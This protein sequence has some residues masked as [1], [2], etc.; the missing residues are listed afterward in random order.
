MP[1]DNA[2]SKISPVSLKSSDQQRK[3]V[4]DAWTRERKISKGNAEKA[5]EKYGQLI[6]K[7][8]DYNS[9][10][11]P[12]S[13]T[14]CENLAEVHKVLDLEGDIWVLNAVQ[15]RYARQQGII[16]RL[17]H[18]TQDELTDKGKGDPVT[19]GLAIIQVIWMIVQLIVR[20]ATNKPSSP[21]ELATL[22]FATLAFV[23]YVLLF[24]HPKDVNTPF[25]IL[26]CRLPVLSEVVQIA[27]LSSDSSAAYLDESTL[28]GSI[29]NLTDHSLGTNDRWAAA[30]YWFIGSAVGGLV[31]GG[32]HLLAWN[33][34]F[35][36]EAERVLWIISC[37]ITALGPLLYITEDIVYHALSHPKRGIWGIGHIETSWGVVGCVTGGVFVL[38]RLFLFVEMFRSLYFLPPGA[39]LSTWTENVPHL[40]G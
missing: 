9:S 28:P 3:D 2:S 32:I 17:C 19:K 26:A 30:P 25:Y 15:L 20:A 13:K 39:F 23:I 37:F 11:G 6:W 7:P 5:S 29:P 16:S 33:F 12:F 21:L 24:N 38:A 10:L 18:I 31:F 1:Y 22:A 8:H 14:H 27:R 34:T 36:S 35:P 40:G 4:A